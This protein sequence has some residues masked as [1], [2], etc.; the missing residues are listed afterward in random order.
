[1]TVPNMLEVIQEGLEGG[2]KGFSPFKFDDCGGK[3]K[4]HLLAFPVMSRPHIY[5]CD[6]E[7]IEINKVTLWVGLDMKAIAEQRS[8][9]KLF[10]GITEEF[11]GGP[12]G[13]AI[14]EETACMPFCQEGEKLVKALLP[15]G[16]PFR[17]AVGEVADSIAY[18]AEDNTE[19]RFPA[20][21]ISVFIVLGL[22]SALVI[23]VGI[24]WHG[25][26]IAVSLRWAYRALGTIRSIV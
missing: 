16:T 3:K 17:Q 22:I 21:I 14:H 4:R 25:R 11:G 23:I 18:W 20:E 26:K 19:V 5:N 24:A 9:C 1:M 2:L 13:N 12:D 15:G 8:D 10:V 7:L 6:G